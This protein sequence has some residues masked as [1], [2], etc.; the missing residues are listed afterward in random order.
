MS[1]IKIHC[2]YDELVDPRTLKNHKDNRNKHPPE[3]IERLAKILD[4]QGWRYAIKVS[5]QT[6]SITSGHG[7]K[8]AALD[9]G[10]KLV[11][12][13]YQD[14]ES[15]EQEYADVQADNA[16]ALWAELD[17]P[18]INSDIGLLGPDFD[19]DLLG[20]NGFKI[21]PSEVDLPNLDAN[22]PDCQQVTFVLSNEQK[23]LL[24]EAM[25]KVASD[26]DCSDEI[27]QNKN[28]NILAALVRAYLRG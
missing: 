18:G 25:A 24:D 22:D 10:W 20:I 21:D 19:I 7:R 1:E 11:P 3:Q 8:L 23:D 6:K 5:K 26:E 27:N 4:Y 15:E 12:V 16:I 2:L 28:G 13:V 14:Y 9:R 17:L